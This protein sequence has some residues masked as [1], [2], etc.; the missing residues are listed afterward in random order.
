MTK[1]QFDVI[2][3]LALAYGHEWA[4]GLD[5]GYAYH[6]GRT[7]GDWTRDH[8]DP[9]KA[10]DPDHT[11]DDSDFAQCAMWKKMLDLHAQIERGYV[12]TTEE[13]A[14]IATPLFDDDNF[15][16]TPHVALWHETCSH[17]TRWSVEADGE[18]RFERWSPRPLWDHSHPH[19]LMAR[20][21]VWTAKSGQRVAMVDAHIP[22]SEWPQHDIGRLSDMLVAAGA[23]KQEAMRAI[24]ATTFGGKPVCHFDLACVTGN[25]L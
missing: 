21:R 2:R 6:D 14:A 5:F 17:Q 3:A 22:I 4:I 9:A 25:A 10:F 13:I 20:A 23:T 8:C 16:S 1:V 24:E 7:R 11:I 18:V 19:A 15:P 12:P